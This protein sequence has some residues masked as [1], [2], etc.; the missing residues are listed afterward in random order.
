M[1]RNENGH[2]PRWGKSPL[3]VQRHVRMSA[4]TARLVDLLSESYGTMNKTIA[5]C[6]ASHAAEVLGSQGV[7][8]K[9]HGTVIGGT[10][11]G[12]EGMGDAQWLVCLACASDAES[13]VS[14]S[15]L[16]RADGRCR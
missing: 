7:C 8:A 12:L 6:V 13:R 5:R 2:R 11:V 9:C 3:P 14:R 15:R 16:C 4:E 10:R 1:P